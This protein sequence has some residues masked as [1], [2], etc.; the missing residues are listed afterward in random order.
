[1]RCLYD[2]PFR[3]IYNDIRWN[4]YEQ[5]SNYL[6][7]TKNWIIEKDTLANRFKKIKDKKYQHEIF[8]NLAS[9]NNLEY[10]ELEIIS[11]LDSLKI[12]GKVSML[13]EQ[14]YM[15][16]LKI[17]SELMIPFT[18]KRPDYVL[19][20]N[21]HLL[22]IEFSYANV[23]DEEY[24]YKTKL[25]QVIQYKN[26]L[27]NILNDVKISTYTFI[28]KPDEQDKNINDNDIKNLANF[29]N[30]FFKNAINQD[31]YSQLNKL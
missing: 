1:M 26:L 19:C 21:N 8:I 10:N 22:I 27:D 2:M 14:E 7:N 28:I 24:R 30:F 18:S 5:G 29:I 15:E 20:L 16:D 6:P 17:I 3:R 13:I 31:A 23:E 4:N 25:S 11:W 12:L 9:K